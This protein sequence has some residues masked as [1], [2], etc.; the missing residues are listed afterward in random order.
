MESLQDIEIHIPQHCSIMM[1]VF[2]PLNIYWHISHF[3]ESGENYPNSQ[4]HKQVPSLLLQTNNFICPPS[5]KSTVSALIK[6]LDEWQCALDQGNEVCVVFFNVSKAF[7]TVFHLPLLKKLSEIGL[8]PLSH[9]V[10][11]KLSSR[12]VSVC[13]Y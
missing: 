7:D 4:R 10:D 3:M 5:C 1:Q 8:D 9:K 2:Q 11:Q 6:V 13:K 12:Q